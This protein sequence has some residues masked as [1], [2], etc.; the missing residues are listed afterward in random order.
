MAELIQLVASNVPAI[1]FAMAFLIAVVR[2][3]HRSFP[4]RLLD[5]LLLLSV[6]VASVWAG[7]FHVFFPGI[8]AQSIGWQVSPFQFEIGV[9]DMAIGIVA[10]V[11]F[12]CSLSFKSAVITYIVLFDI[13]VAIGH[14][15][16]AL[17]AG[18]FAANNF[19]LLLALTIAQIFLFPPL[20]W[21]AWRSETVRSAP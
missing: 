17:E 15:R 5:W 1:M 20:L 18:N 8:A 6:G 21:S 19:G 14:V 16:D 7:A 11:A 10:V 13:G 3:D 9:A 4:D 2:R 12:W